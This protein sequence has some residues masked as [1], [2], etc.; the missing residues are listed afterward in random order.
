MT[1]TIV[2]RGENGPI[3][4]MVGWPAFGS[5]LVVAFA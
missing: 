2:V 1:M 3:R 4:A 5:N